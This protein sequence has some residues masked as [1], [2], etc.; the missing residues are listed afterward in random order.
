MHYQ[1]LLMVNHIQQCSLWGP[2]VKRVISGTLPDEPEEATVIADASD[3]IDQVT[4]TSSPTPTTVQYFQPQ[5]VDAL[6]TAPPPLPPTIQESIPV[7]ADPITQ[8]P[9]SS[10]ESESPPSQSLFQKIKSRIMHV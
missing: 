7:T 8:V 3:S 2:A 10:V 5:S 6:V 9:S 1:Q 4:S